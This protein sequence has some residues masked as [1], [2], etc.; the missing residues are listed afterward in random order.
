MP[1]TASNDPF[2]ITVVGAFFL[3]SR[4]SPQALRP[5]E[6]QA[7]SSRC[8]FASFSQPRRIYAKSF[9]RAAWTYDSSLP[10]TR[11]SGSRERSP[12]QSHKWTSSTRFFPNVTSLCPSASIPG[13]NNSSTT[14]R[15]HA[16]S[17]IWRDWCER[18]CR[19]FFNHFPVF[20]A[21]KSQHP[22]FM[23]ELFIWGD[24]HY[25]ALGNEI[26]ARDLIAQYR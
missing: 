16:R 3:C 7:N 11:I 1:R 10:V 25:T 26:F 4:C 22:D 23:H 2:A 8:G 21:Y 13:P 12:K 6:L 17:T 19:R 14:R 18:K 9:P 5:D 24:S 15:S 20:F